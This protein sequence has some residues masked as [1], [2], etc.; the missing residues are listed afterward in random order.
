M[1]AASADAVVTTA[2]RRGGNFVGKVVG[3]VGEAVQADRGLAAAGAALDDD[4]AGVARGDEIELARIDQRGDLGQVA[5]E[6]LPARGRGAQ[7]AA[8]GADG[9]VLPA[10]ELVRRQVGALPAPPCVARAQTPCG[11][12]TRSRTPPSMVSVRRATISPSTSRS[13][14]RSS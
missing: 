6:R 11:Q 13:P 4:H 10:G 1:Y 5:V 8:R 3:E 9:G 12:A 7:H 2:S 14:K